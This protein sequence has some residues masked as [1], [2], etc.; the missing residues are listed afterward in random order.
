[1]EATDGLAGSAPEQPHTAKRTFVWAHF[2]QYSYERGVALLSAGI[3][4]V[5]ML[6]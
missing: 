1:V 2:Q 4:E 6:Y 5:P 3:D